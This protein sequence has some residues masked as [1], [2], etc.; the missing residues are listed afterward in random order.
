MNA[1]LRELRDK[2]GVL[3][4]DVADAVG[5]SQEQISNLERG[6]VPAD[7][8]LMRKIAEYYGVEVKDRDEKI[9]LYIE[10]IVAPGLKRFFVDFF[11][12]WFSWDTL[13]L[14]VAIHCFSF[15]SI[16]KSD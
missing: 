1:K 12:F 7:T 8:W 3:Q 10:H 15:S 2:K 16:Y 9:G 6:L 4:Q 5:S 11:W 13:K 14:F